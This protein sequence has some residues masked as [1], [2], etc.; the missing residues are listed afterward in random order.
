MFDSDNSDPPARG[1]KKS[2]L[3]TATSWPPVGK[4]WKAIDLSHVNL[5]ENLEIK[6]LEMTTLCAWPAAAV[7]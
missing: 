6:C 2:S 1:K 7:R 3:A 4:A 5:S